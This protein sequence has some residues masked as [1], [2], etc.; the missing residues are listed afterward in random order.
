MSG[1][2]VAPFPYCYRCPV[3]QATEGKYCETNC[4]GNP[5]EQLK[6]LLK[7]QTGQD[8]VAAILIEPSLGEGGYV[9]PPKGFIKDVAALARSIGALFIADEVQT[10][11][12]RSGNYFAIEAEGVVPDILVTAK[13]IANGF[14]LSAIVASGEIM[15]KVKPGSVGG[16]YAGNAVALAAANA[17]ID[18]LTDPREAVLANV[19]ARG[20]QFRS[21]LGEMAKR[22]PHFQIGDIRGRGLWNAIEFKVKS[23]TCKQ[24][25]GAAAM[26]LALCS[27][28]P[29]VS[30]FW[31][32]FFPQDHSTTVGA[33]GKLVKAAYEVELLLMNAGIHETIRFIPPLTISK[34]EMA[35]GLTRLEK[36]LNKV[37]TK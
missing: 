19:N 9:L 5:M 20:E 25:R 27:L 28:S 24:Q 35:E 3:S 29:L 18:I 33:A 17:V 13:G 11:Y 30:A 4:C 7:Q 6:N 32:V 1:V 36:A 8:E 22:N 2:Y 23:N 14:P 10:G 31:P 12:G 21:G 15:S 34:D 16:T 26:P 37:F